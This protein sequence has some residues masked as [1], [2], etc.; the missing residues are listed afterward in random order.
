V[1]RVASRRF[2]TEA[3]SSKHTSL[4]QGQHLEADQRRLLR[5]LVDGDVTDREDRDSVVPYIEWYRSASL[6]RTVGSS[7]PPRMTT[8]SSPRRSSPGRTWRC[9]TP[10]S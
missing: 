5:E 7:S 3:R 8:T 4:D 9:F 2:E 10:P 1:A 6:R